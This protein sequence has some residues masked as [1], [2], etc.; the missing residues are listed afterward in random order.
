MGRYSGYLAGTGCIGCGRELCGCW[1][2]G[3]GAS[4]GSLSVLPSGAAGGGGGW[5]GGRWGQ[6]LVMQLLA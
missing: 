3:E 1:T 2:R 5:G 4:P 6:W